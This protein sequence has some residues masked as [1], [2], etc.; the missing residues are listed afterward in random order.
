MENASLALRAYEVLTQGNWNVEQVRETLKS[1]QWEGRME[2]IL[3]DVYVDGA[4]NEDGIRDFLETVKQDKQEKKR[5]LV[6]SVVQDKAYEEMIGELVGTGL[7]QRYIVVHM[8]E[9]RCASKEQLQKIFGRYKDVDVFYADTVEE[10]LNVSV[11]RKTEDEIIYIA[12]SLYLVG[13][14][15]AILGRK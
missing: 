11:G 3:P 13:F 10:G 15:K 2:E 9:E 6:F 14:V 1:V 12:G 7:F 4:H 5:V 8:P